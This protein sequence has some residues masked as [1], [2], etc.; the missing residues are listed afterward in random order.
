[1]LQKVPKSF[2]D[3]TKKKQAGSKKEADGDA[4]HVFF[5]TLPLWPDVS[6]LDVESFSIETA[7]IIVLHQ[8]CFY[9]IDLSPDEN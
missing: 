8:S 4:K 9:I 7:L 2:K 5:F 1:M 6:T 3:Q